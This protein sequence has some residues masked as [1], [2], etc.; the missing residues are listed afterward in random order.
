MSLEHSPTR[1]N[2]TGGK[3]YLTSLMVRQRY[4]NCSDMSLWRWLNDPAL[5][6][7]KPAF[8]INGRRFF[9]PETLDQFDAERRAAS[10]DDADGDGDDGMAAA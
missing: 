4:G 3:E 2:R 10:G 9:D 6:F 1:A 8:K 7:P 5:N